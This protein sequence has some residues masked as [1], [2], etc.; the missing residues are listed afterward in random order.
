GSTVLRHVIACT[1]A[2]TSQLESVGE[3]ALLRALR[4]AGLP[5]PTPQHWVVVGGERHRIDLAYPDERIALEYDGEEA[6]A[7]VQA[8]LDDA[9]RTE[10]LRAAG[11]TVHRV[12]KGQD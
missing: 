9:A 6:H 11:W 1:S 7:G 10:R 5:H 12:R 3:A 2:A 8:T 4:D